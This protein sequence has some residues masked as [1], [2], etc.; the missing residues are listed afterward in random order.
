MDIGLSVNLSARDIASMEAVGT[1]TQIVRESAVAPHRIDFEI[2]ET[3]IVCD[4][5]QARAALQALHELG[6][7]TALDDFG[8][9]HSSLTHVRLLPLDRLKVDASFIADIMD[10][11]ASEDIVKTV[12]E[13]CRNL[14][15]SCVVE[16]VET[17]AQQRKVAELGGV[18][19]QGFYYSRPIP[20][21]RV[22]D[23]LIETNRAALPTSAAVQ[24]LS[25]Q[26][27]A[28]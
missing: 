26:R 8:T 20:A 16:G 17:E 3:A 18:L 2:T 15:V 10:H 14:R 22:G 11:R 25:G 12:L 28:S 7:R 19:M 13:L 5:D 6:A 21:E 23:Y 24:I 9:G 1:I 4:F 27:K